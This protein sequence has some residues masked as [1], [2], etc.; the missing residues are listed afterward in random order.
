MDSFLFLLF[1][2]VSGHFF[3]DVFLL[4]LQQEHQM[5]ENL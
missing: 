4:M 5:C 2:N 1:L 3:S